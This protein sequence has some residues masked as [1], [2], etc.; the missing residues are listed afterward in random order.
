MFLHSS[1]FLREAK[2]L[3]MAGGLLFRKSTPKSNSFQ[4]NLV[5]NVC[6]KASGLPFPKQL[7]LDAGCSAQTSSPS[8]AT[9]TKSKN[10]SVQVLRG[11]GQFHSRVPVTRKSI[12]RFLTT[13]NA[14]VPL[15][16]SCLACGD[17]DLSK[18]VGKPSLFQQSSFAKRRPPSDA[19]EVGNC[20]LIRGVGSP[21]LVVILMP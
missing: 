19:T 4:L 11:P 17:S 1:D 18:T 16:C 2:L 13:L 3:L 5:R 10:S 14:R 8:F 20:P 12:K 21:K 7:L 15:D 9:S 6:H